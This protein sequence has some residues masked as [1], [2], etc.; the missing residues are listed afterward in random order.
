MD[1][2]Y[3]WQL[4]GAWVGRDDG[5]MME[6]LFVYGSLAPGRPN[7]S[8]LAAVA[9][10]W[11]TATVRGHLRHEGWGAAIG[12]PGLVLA[13]D[14]KEL[15]GL[16]FC[17][18]QLDSHWAW[19]DQFEGEGYQRVPVSATLADGSIVQAQVYALRLDVQR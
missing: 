17:S 18:D 9:G 1:G 3:Y 11:V 14:G 7:E 12:F 19:L 6:R 16:L 4:T 5:T 15:P 13:D 2:E 10:T 8:V